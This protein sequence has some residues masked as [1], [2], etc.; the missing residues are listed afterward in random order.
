MPHSESKKETKETMMTNDT[1]VTT[2]TAV[3]AR[4]SRRQQRREH[5]TMMT[6]D[7]T[8]TARVSRR[9][10]LLAAQRELADKSTWASIDRHAAAEAYARKKTGE[11]RAFTNEVHAFI[12]L[13]FGT[14][15]GR[16]LSKKQ[17]KLAA[18]AVSIAA[19]IKKIDDSAAAHAA[20][21]ASRAAAK[22]SRIDINKRISTATVYSFSARRRSNWGVLTTFHTINAHTIKLRPDGRY[23]VGPTKNYE[24]VHIYREDEAR[25]VIESRGDVFVSG[26]DS[27]I[28]KDGIIEILT[29]PSSAPP[30][31]R[32]VPLDEHN[33]Q[34]DLRL[35]F[36]RYVDILAHPSNPQNKYARWLVSL[37]ACSA[38]I[39]RALSTESR[40]PYD[41]VRIGKS[42]EV[43]WLR[44]HA[45]LTD[46]GQ[47][48]TAD[49]MA[50]SSITFTTWE[51]F[52]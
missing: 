2:V 40:S 3:T 10:Q 23:I 35:L 31:G 49:E 18:S 27:E 46:T 11:A 34:I 36:E 50:T 8:V 33:R 15:A 41:T 45:T 17:E 29:K 22:Q 13:F 16:S 6:N 21:V 14:R 47:C 7:T 4:A 9:Q 44:S 48:P 39:C 20:A 42:F 19:K 28:P 12:V 30:D 26:P 51:K 38:G 1:T 43:F 25:K 5:R 37:G 24:T 52:V 32:F